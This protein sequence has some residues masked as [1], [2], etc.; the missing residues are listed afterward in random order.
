M[1]LG[2]RVYESLIDCVYTIERRRARNVGAQTGDRIRQYGGDGR[3]GGCPSSEQRQNKG[4][5]SRGHLPRPRR[6]ICS[7]K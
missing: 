3:V 5:S 6:I 2:C 4:C 7:H 1:E